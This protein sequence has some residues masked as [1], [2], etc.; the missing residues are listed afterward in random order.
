MGG[1]YIYNEIAGKAKGK[2]DFG[3]QRGHDGKDECKRQHQHHH[4]TGREKGGHKEGILERQCFFGKL[5]PIGRSPGDRGEFQNER[6][7]K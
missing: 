2:D 1:G 5:N 3:R 4:E 6:T 7:R